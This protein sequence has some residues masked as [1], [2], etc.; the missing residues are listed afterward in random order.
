MFWVEKII[1][2]HHTHSSRDHER[3][4]GM[5]EYFFSHFPDDWG[6]DN[7]NPEKLRMEST[8]E[9]AHNN[10]TVDIGYKIR[11]GTRKK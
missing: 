10:N 7:L 11:S 4:N 8:K 2:C 6:D 1:N 3:K 5:G 9:V